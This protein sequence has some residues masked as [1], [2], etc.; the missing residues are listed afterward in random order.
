MPVWAKKRMELGIP[1][2][3]FLLISAGELNANKN[4]SVIISAMEKLKKPN[5]HYILCGVGEKQT[6]L[7]AQADKAGLHGKVHFL[8]Y[9]TDVKELYE[10]SD[11]FV[12]PSFREGLSRSIMET[13]ASGLPCVVSKIRGNVDLIDEGKGGAT[14]DPYSIV[15]C[16]NA[17][18]KVLKSDYSEISKYNLE[19]IKNFSFDNV[20]DKIKKI[21]KNI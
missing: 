10:A 2:D 21:Y 19:K 9:R 1:L 16:K 14:F 13:M 7:Q 12:M 17:I 20:K 11:C 6:E 3:A 5:I 4:N 18:Q 15:D 8:G